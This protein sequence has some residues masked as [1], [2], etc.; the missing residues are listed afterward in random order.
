M[1]AARFGNVR[2]VAAGCPHP[3]IE[4]VAGIGWIEVSA[5]VP[6]PSALRHLVGSNRRGDGVLRLRP[7]VFAVAKT[8]PQSAHRLASTRAGKTHMDDQRNHQGAVAG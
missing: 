5:D 3:G 7:A 6:E 4:P 2:P 1:V 8:I